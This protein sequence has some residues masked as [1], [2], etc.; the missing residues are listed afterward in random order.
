MKPESWKLTNL[1]NKFHLSPLRNKSTFF[2]VGLLRKVCFS[3][4]LLVLFLFADQALA[5]NITIIGDSISPAAPG[6]GAAFTLSVTYVNDATYQ[7]PTSW[8]VAF[9]SDGSTIVGCPAAGQVFLVDNKGINVGDPGV[10][11]SAMGWGGPSY[12]LGVGPVASDAVSTV[13]P[14]TFVQTYNLSVPSSAAYGGKL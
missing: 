13:A 7:G 14:I 5:Q 3:S 11:G 4:L 12:E 2:P 10:N 6:P 9:T 8:L 1:V